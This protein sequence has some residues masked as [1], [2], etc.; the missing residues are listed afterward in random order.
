MV[1]LGFPSNVIS[2]HHEI[3]E[4]CHVVHTTR[5]DILNKCDEPHGQWLIPNAKHWMVV[6]CIFQ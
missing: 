6:K 2:T 5:F 1:K 4:V 3:I